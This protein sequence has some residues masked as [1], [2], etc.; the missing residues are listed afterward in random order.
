MAETDEEPASHGI[1]SAT[2][3]NLTRR[4]DVDN[5]LSGT[6]QSSLS[7]DCLADIDDEEKARV[8]ANEDLLGPR[9]QVRYSFLQ[10]TLQLS[11]LPL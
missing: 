1:S 7:S 11:F 5:G 4:K 2:K 8:I 9:K 10:Y 3:P 6:G